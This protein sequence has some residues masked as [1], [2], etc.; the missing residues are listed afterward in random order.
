MPGY[1]SCASKPVSLPAAP[2]FLRKNLYDLW[3]RR[4]K[5]RRQVRISKGINIIWCVCQDFNSKSTHKPLGISPL[6]GPPAP[7][8]GHLQCFFKY[9][10]H[11][12]LPLLSAPC[13]HSQVHPKSQLSSKHRRCPDNRPR[14]VHKEESTN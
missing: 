8:F 12:S 10:T 3:T 9:Q 13:V 1:H 6:W 4:R 7:G 11:T 5:G 14:S 2:R